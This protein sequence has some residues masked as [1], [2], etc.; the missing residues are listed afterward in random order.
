MLGSRCHPQLTKSG[1]ARP[2][3]PAHRAPQPA[4]ELGGRAGS[5]SGGSGD[6]ERRFSSG[7]QG[8]RRKKARQPG[9]FEVEDVSPPKRSLGIHALPPNTH[10]GDQIAVAGSSYVV[11]SVVMQYKLVRGKYCREHARL[12]VQGTGRYLANSFLEGLWQLEAP[13]PPADDPGPDTSQL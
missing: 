4:A 1:S 9:L 8:G 11:Q 12:E 6:S 5:S 10:N 13:P 2:Q 7:R 3:R